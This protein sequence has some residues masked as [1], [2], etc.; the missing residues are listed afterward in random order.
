M[1]GSIASIFLPLVLV[2]ALGLRIASARELLLPPEE[3]RALSTRWLVDDPHTAYHLRRIEL[4][5]SADHAPLSDEF[6]SHPNA[7]EIPWLPLYDTLLAAIA[8]PFAWQSAD[9]S[10]PGHVD[11]ARLENFLLRVPPLLGVLTALCVMWSVGRHARGGTRRAAAMF[12]AAVVAVA[13][14]TVEQS[15]AGRLD[16]LGWVALL[17][18]LDILITQTALRAESPLEAFLGALLAGLVAGL[19]MSSFALGFALFLPGWLGFV[20]AAYGA[21]EGRTRIAQRAGLL[22]CLVAALA[23][24]LPLPEE[25]RTF[26]S[27]LFA[28]WWTVSS[29]AVLLSSTPFLIGYLL[30]GRRTGRFFQTA[31]LAVALG[32]ILFYVPMLWSVFGRALVWYQKERATIALVSPGQRPIFSSAG[33][34]DALRV[35]VSL[36][37]LFVLY[38]PAW[39]WSCRRWRSGEHAM[40]AAMGAATFVLA[41][42]ERRAGGLLAVPMACTLGWALDTF[43]ETAIGRA[44]KIGLALAGCAIVVMAAQATAG[45]AVALHPAGREERVQFV[46]GLRWMRAS[47]AAPDA[48]RSPSSRPEGGVLSSFSCGAL[49]AYHARQPALC[50]DLAILAGD[51]RL[52]ETARA[53]LSEDPAAVVRCLHGNQGEYVIVG[54]RT[55]IDESA[56]RELAALVDHKAAAHATPLEQSALGRL[57][58]TP[59]GCAADHF[60]GLVR[61][62]RSDLRVSSLVNGRASTG[63]AISIYKLAEPAPIAPAAVIQPR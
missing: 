51:E 62:Y 44:R 45:I 18:A 17:V 56:L 57:A 36:G 22:Y 61:I 38:V 24:H 63:P 29:Q 20:I 43:F 23:G 31:V 5:M 59:E 12:A 8:R 3:S 32:A 41:L 13:P 35:W 11:E 6:L 10:T 14:L 52:R 33:G 58:L 49:I 7:V 42:F 54:P 26:D 1:R 39:V 46:K 2:L 48:S 37:P 40:L 21:E 9:F 16:H 53:L 34:F 55:L 47:R 30:P 28:D 4:T 60:P 27:G 19:S 15:S 25:A 50:S